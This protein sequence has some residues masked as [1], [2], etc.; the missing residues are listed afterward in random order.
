MSSNKSTEAP[1]A[2][3]AKRGSGWDAKKAMKDHNWREVGRQET[4][5]GVFQLWEVTPPIRETREGKSWVS[6]APDGSIIYH[7]VKCISGSNRT[8]VIHKKVQMN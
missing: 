4:P 5:E 1:A 2:K 7:E 8:A 6:Q 3:R